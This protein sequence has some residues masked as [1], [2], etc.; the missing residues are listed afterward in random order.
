MLNTNAEF[1]R[2]FCLRFPEG[3]TGHAGHIQSSVIT[4]SCNMTRQWL[5][6]FINS[7]TFS[8]LKCPQGVAF[9]FDIPTCKRSSIDFPSPDIIT[10]HY[11][12]CHTN[13]MSSFLKAFSIFHFHKRSGHPCQLPAI[14]VILMSPIHFRLDL[15]MQ[16]NLIVD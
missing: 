4:L 2:S 5:M 14:H 8:W 3:A 10:N 9:H 12:L 7:G 15:I 6:I 13:W 1:Y 16:Y 11:Q